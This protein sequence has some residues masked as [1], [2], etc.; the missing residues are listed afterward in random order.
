MHGLN[1]FPVIYALA[2]FPFSLPLS[3]SIHLLHCLLPIL[4]FYMST[5]A[6]LSHCSARS[7]SLWPDEIYTHKSRKK[8]NGLLSVCF[9]PL[10]PVCLCAYSLFVFVIFPFS[11]SNS[12]CLR[13]DVYLM[14]RLNSY[15]LF[16]MYWHRSAFIASHN[17]SSSLCRWKNRRCHRRRSCRPC[18]PCCAPMNKKRKLHRRKR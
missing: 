14:Y 1:F 9:A 18:R 12:F 2:L 5:T 8:K 15:G 7:S 10:T 17:S 13:L 6:A 3:L 16:V 4:K 11:G